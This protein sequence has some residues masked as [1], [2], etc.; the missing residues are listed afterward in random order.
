[1]SRINWKQ[2]MEHEG[3]AL[4]TWLRDAEEGC[5][6][7]IQGI[8]LFFVKAI[9]ELFHDFLRWLQKGFLY[10]CRVA[11]RIS[12][13]AALFAA[14]AVIVFVPVV[15]YMNFVTAAWA[16]LAFVGSAYGMQ[17]R[18]K[19]KKGATAFQKEARHARA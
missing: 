5:V 17:R 8:W 2:L 4:L 9:P 18:I 3:D 19:M 15:V 12:R 16:V 11:V 13:L 14:W 1:M 6:R 7:A 10:A